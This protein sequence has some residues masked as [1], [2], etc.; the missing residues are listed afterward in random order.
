MVNLMA[1]TVVVLISADGDFND[2]CN[3]GNKVAGS[4]NVS[5]PKHSAT[6]LRVPS[7]VHSQCLYRSIQIE[8]TKFCKS[9]TPDGLADW[10]VMICSAAYSLCTYSAFNENNSIKT[11]NI[12]LLMNAREDI[13]VLVVPRFLLIW[14]V[15]ILE[16]YRPLCFLTCN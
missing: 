9:D 4:I 7:S 11:R 13:D 2:S 6:T 10:Q 5:F 1:V 12:P 3:L 15:N 8:G 14:T 16:D